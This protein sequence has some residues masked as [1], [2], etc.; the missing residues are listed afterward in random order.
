MSEIIVSLSGAGQYSLDLSIVDPG[1]EDSDIEVWR[2][3]FTDKEGYD[4]DW[5]VYFEMSPDYEVWDLIDE[6]ISAYRET[7]EELD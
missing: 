3:I 2:A 5:I 6:A 4:A 7:I 1:A